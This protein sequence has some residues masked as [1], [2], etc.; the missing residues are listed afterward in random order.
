M[1]TFSKQKRR[2]L[3]TTCGIKNCKRLTSVAEI[4]AEIEYLN[5]SELNEKRKVYWS[6][7]LEHNRKVFTAGNLKICKGGSWADKLVYTQPGSRQGI[8]KEK[9]SSKIGFRVVLSD[10]NDAMKKYFPKKNWVP[11]N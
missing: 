1:L 11:N 9:A 2:L 5:N 8:N 7:I 6:E 3:K 4:D 10:T